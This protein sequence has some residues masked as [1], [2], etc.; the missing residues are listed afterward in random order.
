MSSL[1]D[2]C[3][4]TAWVKSSFTWPLVTF[5]SIRCGT[6]HRSTRCTCPLRMSMRA[7]SL[8]GVAVTGVATEPSAGRS[9]TSRASSP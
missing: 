9:E 4:I 2:G 7:T 6:T 5:T 1:S 3:V 8:A